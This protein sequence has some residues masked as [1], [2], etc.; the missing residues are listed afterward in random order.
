MR[1]EKI[2]MLCAL[3]VFLSFGVLAQSNPSVCCER[4]KSGAVCVNTDEN[5]CAP[6]AKRTPTSCESTSYCKPGTCYDS[7]EG[8]CLEN[9]PQLVC[10][11]NGG[12]WDPRSASEI[13]QCNL[14]CCL[15]GDQ[16]SFVTLTRCKKLSS[17]FGLENNFRSDVKDELSCID[18]ARS[19]EKGACVIE[20]DFEKTCRF[21]TRSE[22][23]D[24]SSGK[25]YPGLLCSAEEL[26]T[27]CARQVRTRCF[28]GKVYWVDS[29]GNLENVYSSDKDKSWNGGRVAKP[30]EVCSPNDGSNKNCG[31]CDYLRGTS[32]AEYTSPIGKPKGSDF[33]CRRTTCK[34][35]SGKERK[36]G[37][38][39]CE[40]D[41]EV[42]DSKDKVGS[43]HFK[44][45][46]V[47]GEVIIEPCADFRNEI[48]IQDSVKI[49]GSGENFSYA[50]CIANRWQDCL[51]QKTKKD[52]TD[53]LKRDCRWIKRPKG[54]AESFGKEKD[55]EGVTEGIIEDETKEG[56]CVPM[57]PPGLK[58]WDKSAE[59]VCKLGNA[60]CTY[61]KKKSLTGGKQSES[62]KECLTSD[63]AAEVNNFC[64]S[65]GDCGGS[66]NYIGDFSDD[67]Y[68]WSIDGETKKVSQVTINRWASNDVWLSL[69]N[70]IFNMLL[71]EKTLSDVSASEEKKNSLMDILK[72]RL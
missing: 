16:A 31:N 30:E 32:C 18:L 34:D 68:V 51:L 25:F 12:K 17:F 53:N 29:C 72:D 48:C 59:K 43:R 38:S 47:D 40:Y 54:I 67:G 37:E 65:L 1:I 52:C 55:V 22:C 69:A 7:S 42:G 64:Q 27:S 28:D 9:T 23:S 3:V 58:F 6:G 61:I 11:K 50:S 24:N 44:K 45:R 60:K 71:G 70:G 13:S 26:G 49:E 20:K 56:V 63:W 66:E 10:E 5:N 46:C 14:G 21:V 41:G 62:G 35:S 19:Q 8:T 33:Y 36:N 4:T 15:I 2:I 39:W 57:Y